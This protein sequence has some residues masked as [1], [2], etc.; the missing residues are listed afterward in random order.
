MESVRESPKI[1]K[2][3]PK[4]VKEGAQGKKEI[5]KESPK[6]VKESA[7]VVLTDYRHNEVQKVGFSAIS[8]T[9]GME[10]YDIFNCQ[11]T[12]KVSSVY[13]NPRCLVGL[14]PHDSTVSVK[15]SRTRDRVLND[16]L[17]MCE[18][19]C[20]AGV[21]YAWHD[22]VC[23]CQHDDEEV[24]EM[25]KCM[26]WVYAYA[27]E[28]IIFL[29]YVGKPMAPIGP[30]DGVNELICRWHT[31][32]WT[33][34]EGALSNRRRYWVKDF[35]AKDEYMELSTIQSFERQEQP[36]GLAR[37][38]FSANASLLEEDVERVQ[39]DGNLELTAK[40]LCVAVRFMTE[41]RRLV[42]DRA[43]DLN[44]FVKGVSK[45]ICIDMHRP[46]LKMYTAPLLRLSRFQAT[47]P[48][49]ACCNLGIADVLMYYDNSS[50]SGRSSN[51]TSSGTQYNSNTDHFKRM[52]EMGDGDIFCSSHAPF[53]GSEQGTNYLQGRH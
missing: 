21:E 44:R 40:L 5:V 7:Q 33:L 26:G 16:I 25:I 31:R 1:V 20:K 15:S 12:T 19:L 50:G 8:H 49:N 2:E 22:G 28:T 36:A 13:M 6:S 52:D 51:S 45:E 38:L 48:E 4:S 39:E 34:Q 10:V 42:I 14:C 53:I 43:Q 29:H 3:S 24:K 47:A 27:K 46:Y 35:A 41:Q 30:G 32:V 18:N 9:Y 37:A 17:S 11:C 23:I